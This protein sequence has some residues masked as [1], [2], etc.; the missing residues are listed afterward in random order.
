MSGDC[1]LLKTT[2]AGISSDGSGWEPD[3]STRAGSHRICEAPLIAGKPSEHAQ[4]GIRA[5]QKQ[6]HVI[7]NVHLRSQ[8]GNGDIIANIGASWASK[9]GGVL[10]KMTDQEKMPICWIHPAQFANSLEE[11]P[12]K[13]TRRSKV[14]TMWQESSKTM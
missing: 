5:D 9:S 7:K 6:Q 11:A 4:S 13:S 10:H 12:V 8:I 3:K 1:F 2:I 14:R